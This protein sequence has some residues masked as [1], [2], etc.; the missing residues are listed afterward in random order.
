MCYDSNPAARLPK[1]N[2]ENY[3]NMMWLLIYLQLIAG[4]RLDTGA[5]EC[6]KKR[7]G[8]RIKNCERR[9]SQKIR[10]EV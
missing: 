7:L 2:K 6:R 5:D 10:E 9:V 3:Y 4:G 8:S 1:Q